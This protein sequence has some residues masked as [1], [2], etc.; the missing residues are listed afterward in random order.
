MFVLKHPMFV[1][2]KQCF[3]FFLHN[4]EINANHGKP[5]TNKIQTHFSENAD[6][7]NLIHTNTNE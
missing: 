1:L 6:E 3:W 2:T 5:N 4:T 7:Y